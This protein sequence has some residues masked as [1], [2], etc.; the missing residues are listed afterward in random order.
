MW[1]GHEAR[2]FPRERVWPGSETTYVIAYMY[3]VAESKMILFHILV[4]IFRWL[5]PW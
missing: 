4:F 2:P 1:A 3:Q 5:L